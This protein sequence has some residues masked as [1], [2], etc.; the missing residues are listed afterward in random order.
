MVICITVVAAYNATAIDIAIIIIITII[1]RCF[2][3]VLL[4]QDERF[5]FCPFLLPDFMIVHN[6]CHIMP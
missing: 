1:F 4:P 6:P 2:S 5:P 3:N